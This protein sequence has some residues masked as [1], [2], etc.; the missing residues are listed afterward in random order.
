MLQRSYKSLF[1][2]GYAAVLFTS[3]LKLNWH[4][5]KVKVNLLA[6]DLRLDHL[7]HLSAYYLICMYYLAGQRLGLKLFVSHTF[8][9]FIIVTTLQATITEIVQ[10]WVPSRSFNVL[11]WLAN[12]AGIGLG[13]IAIKITE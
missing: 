8:R 2:L 13:V 3:V 12:V 4:L 9:K 10:I 7:L 1:W 11:D 5:D 6:F